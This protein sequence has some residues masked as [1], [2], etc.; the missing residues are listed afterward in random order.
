LPVTAKPAGL[1]AAAKMHFSS[2]SRFFPCS[3]LAF[4]VCSLILLAFSIRLPES[5][6]DWLN[7]NTARMA[8]CCL[9]LVGMHPLLHGRTLS[10]DGFAIAVVTECSTLYM[11]I[12]FF[13][14]VVASP[15]DLRRKLAGLPLGVAVLHAGNILRIAAIFAIGVKYRSS[16]EI[17]HVYFGQVLM[18]F[19][20][21]TVCLAWFGTGPALGASNRK[22]PAFII[23]FFAFTSIPFLLWLPLN[24]QYAQFAYRAAAALLVALFGYQIEVRFHPAIYYHTFNAVTFTGLVLATRT[25]HMR[26]KLLV[27]AAGHTAIFSLFLFRTCTVLAAACNHQHADRLG[28]GIALCSQYILPVALWLTMIR[29]KTTAQNSVGA[30]NGIR[31]GSSERGRRNLGK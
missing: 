30:R 13:S 7:E 27:L 9:N 15:A 23:R 11:G 21:L 6:F 2:G 12:L 5:N 17:A 29:S 22:L 10:Q 1:K 20:V 25:R 24:E 26:R 8:A 4:V 19:L 31:T 3:L 14:F 28:G 18:A 16:F